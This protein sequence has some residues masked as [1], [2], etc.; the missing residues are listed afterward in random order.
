MVLL[1]RGGH[2]I[3]HSPSRR[4]YDAPHFPDVLLGVKVKTQMTYVQKY[5]R[6]NITNSSE[7]HATGG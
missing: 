1:H 3:H 2:L 7:S 5:V 4:G 6:E